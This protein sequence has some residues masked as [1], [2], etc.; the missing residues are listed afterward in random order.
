MMNEEDPLVLYTDASKKTI[1]GLLMEV[2]NGIGKPIIF[3]SHVLYDQATR[4]GIMDLELYSF[5]SCVKTL[6]PY[7]LGKHFTVRATL[8][9]ATFC[10]FRIRRLVGGFFSE[11]Q[12][13]I[14]HTR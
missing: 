14:Q 12:F 8:S 3:V 10:I 1:G 7:V 9:I 13:V 2:H 4:W 11:F 5:V 6:A